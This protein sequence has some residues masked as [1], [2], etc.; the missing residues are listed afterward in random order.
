MAFKTQ[1]FTVRISW[2]PNTINHK[3]IYYLPLYSLFTLILYF[4]T[5][6]HHCMLIFTFLLYIP[7]CVIITNFNFLQQVSLFYNFCSN[8]IYKSH[9][10]F[11]C[12]KLHHFH[13]FFCFKINEFWTV[14]RFF[15]V[16]FY[17]QKKFIHPDESK[18]FP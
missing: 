9:D 6:F 12:L 7:T 16:Y 4:N 10:N 18:S 15:Q 14:H 11:F 8:E 17:I 5:K 1:V 3:F 13:Q 2:F